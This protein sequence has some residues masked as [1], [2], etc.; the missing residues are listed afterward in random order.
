M[1]NIHLPETPIHSQPAIKTRYC[2]IQR[3]IRGA[4]PENGIWYLVRR[5]RIHPT[6]IRRVAVDANE[7]SA[8]EVRVTPPSIALDVWLGIKP[9]HNLTHECGLL[10]DVAGTVELLW[11]IKPVRNLW[12]I[13]WTGWGNLPQSTKYLYPPQQHGP[14]QYTW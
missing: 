2:P 8:L 5:V 14:P 7:S 10:V 12:A 6:E 1:T 9:R 4:Y 13:G 11:V 3:E